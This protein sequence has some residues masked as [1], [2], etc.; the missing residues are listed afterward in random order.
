MR[1]LRLA[2]LAG[3]VSLATDLAEGRPAGQGLR[4]AVFAVRIAELLELDPVDRHEAF[5]VALLRDLGCT[6]RAREL[7]VLAEDDIAAQSRVADVDLRRPRG[8]MARVAR[9][10][11]DGKR[12]GRARATLRGLALG[13]RVL[14]RVYRA[15]AEAA[16]TLSRWLGLRSGVGLALHHVHER[17]D[18]HGWPN[19]VSRESTP[20]TARIARIAHVLAAPAADHPEDLVAPLRE[21]S[22][23]DHDP[24]LVDLVDRRA[25]TVLARR[26]QL[27]WDDMLGA[28]P[29]PRHTIAE[30]HLDDAIAAVGHF[31]D[32]KIPFLTG[33]SAAVGALASDAA[34]ELDLARTDIRSLLHAGC[35]HDL[36]R[37]AV[38]LGVWT[39]EDEPDERGWRSIRSHSEHS[40]RL[41]ARST[42]LAHLGTIVGRH[43]ERLDGSGYHRAAPEADQPL[44][45]RILAAADVYQALTEPRPYRPALDPDDAAKH[46]R[47]EVSD[48][49]LGRDS[50]EAT[51]H[52]A[53]RRT[54]PPGRTTWPAALTH[55]E[56]Q[57][58][59]LA[60]EG[61]DD[62]RIS[63]R[64]HITTRT[65]ASHLQTIGMKLGVSS[66]A[67]AT[68]A[69]VEHAIVDRTRLTPPDPATRPLPRYQR[70]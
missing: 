35:L 27:G 68:L 69:A 52:A 26:P 21:R 38:P 9:G 54:P 40:E 8:A 59:R 37:V 60:A 16:S 55:R 67:A 62:E 65:V 47:R 58:L 42:T 11:A 53:A 48:G 7:Q 32:L 29:T 22:G 61:E 2:E 28:E 39:D 44:L 33:H 45:G 30:E 24:V 56:V 10:A 50:V 57:V 66:R 51:L 18:G 63:E 25:S 4:A 20:V 43:H 70:R 34:R 46:L 64:L 49:R 15:D 3:V 36:G 6:A 31:G 14:H 17:W 5:Y 41:L 23:K 13:P 1:R 12:A 19:G